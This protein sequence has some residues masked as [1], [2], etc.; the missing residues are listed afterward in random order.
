M[1]RLKKSLFICLSYACLA[2]AQTPLVETQRDN[3][4]IR[5]NYEI[6]SKKIFEP[7]IIKNDASDVARLVILPDKISA[8]R[9]YIDLEFSPYSIEEEIWYGVAPDRIEEKQLAGAQ[10]MM[11]DGYTYEV[12]YRNTPFIKYRVC[13]LVPLDP[14]TGEMSVDYVTLSAPTIEDENKTI[15]QYGKLLTQSEIKK[16]IRCELPFGNQYILLDRSIDWKFRIDDAN[17][18]G[19]QLL[20]EAVLFYFGIRAFG[21]AYQALVAQYELTTIAQT[22]AGFFVA[23]YYS[24]AVTEL[25]RYGFHFADT[26][27]RNIEM[28]EKLT[29]SYSAIMKFDTT[30]PVMIGVDQGFDRYKQYY[31]ATEGDPVDF[32]DKMKLH[33]FDIGKNYMPEPTVLLKLTDLT[34]YIPGQNNVIFVNDI[35]EGQKTVKSIPASAGTHV[36]AYGKPQDKNLVFVSNPGVDNPK[37]INARYLNTV[38]FHEERREQLLGN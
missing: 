16:D 30:K 1:I 31:L 2:N 35:S 34:P 10:L 33:I 32:I 9:V 26:Q 3:L 25:S 23:G 36:V 6:G 37:T 19:K 12:T 29:L 20:T 11:I 4:T 7:R 13:T 8:H 15:V 24:Y 27:L 14:K 18:F 21:L 17:H 28:I 5:R 22:T 38:I